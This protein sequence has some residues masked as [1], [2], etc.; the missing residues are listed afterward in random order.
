MATS[1]HLLADPHGDWDL[2]PRAAAGEVQAAADLF[3]GHGM[4]VLASTRTVLGPRHDEKAADD[5]VVAAFVAACRGARWDGEQPRTV[6]VRAA[7]DGCLSHAKTQDLR[8]RALLALTVYGRMTCRQASA[9]L[10]IDPEID[11][12]EVREL[13]R[14][15]RLLLDPPRPA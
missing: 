1:L 6:L 2:L 15:L 7:V 13:W 3:D 12:L 10:G 5:I 4:A 8:S 14:E 11:A 9:F